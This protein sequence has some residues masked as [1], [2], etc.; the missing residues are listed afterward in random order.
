MAV[1]TDG[2]GY[3]YALTRSDSEVGWRFDAAGPVRSALAVADSTVFAADTTGAFYA[4]DVQSGEAWWQTQD[5]SA[6][7]GLG[8]VAAGDQ[9]IT[10]SDGLSG[11]DVQTGATQWSLDVGGRLA[12]T[13]VDGTVYIAPPTDGANVRAIDARTGDTRWSSAELDVCPS[14][15]VAAPPVVAGDSVYVAR[16]AAGTGRIFTLDRSDG[17]QIWTTETEQ[18]MTS[19]AAGGD[20]VYYSQERFA[21]S[22]VYALN[23]ADGSV[24]WAFNLNEREPP[25]PDETHRVRSLTATEESVYAMSIERSEEETE[26]PEYTGFLHAFDANGTRRWSL[27]IDSSSAPVVDTAPVVDDTVFATGNRRLYA[28][29]AADGSVVER[30]EPVVSKRSTPAVS[31]DSAFVGSDDE[32][33]YRFRR[34]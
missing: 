18:E 17:S 28:V 15:E 6:T 30:V 26:D 16:N 9:V 2:D 27:T 20:G 29:N 23:G 5:G 24:R 14:L 34:P 13:A 8:I 1:R 32:L 3:A 31:G 12:R 10:I 19:L 4:V 11:F 22:T 25:W 21:D 7:A 33:L